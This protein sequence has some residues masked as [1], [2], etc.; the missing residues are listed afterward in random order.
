MTEM[1]TVWVQPE[2]GDPDYDDRNSFGYVQREEEQDVY[3]PENVIFQHPLPG[4]YGT[5]GRNK[6]EGPG[7]FSLDMAMGKTFQLTE[8]KSIGFRMDAG[9]ILNHPSPGGGGTSI[10]QGSNPLGYIGSKS[11]NRKF[12]AKITIRF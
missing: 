9:N 4:E 2:A 1:V 8:G 11:G 7:T 10:S 3:S 12:Q 5:Y 6:I